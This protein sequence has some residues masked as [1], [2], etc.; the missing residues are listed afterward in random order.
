M[1]ELKWDLNQN[2]G[3]NLAE[4]PKGGKGEMREPKRVN[5]GGK[6]KYNLLQYHGLRKNDEEY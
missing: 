2:K 6:G 1:D 3:D 5:L 4:G